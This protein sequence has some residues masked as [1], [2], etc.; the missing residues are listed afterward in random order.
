[1]GLEFEWEALGELDPDR[2]RPAGA[3]L[4]AL[5]RKELIRPHEAIEDTFHFRHMLIRDAAYE[6]I[7]KELRSEFHER[8]AGWL[9]GR[10]EEFD[11][12]VGY[13]LEEAY[14]C[15]AALG[16]L[17]EK[18]RDLGEASAERLTASGRRAY[19]RADPQAA[20]NLLERAAG[21]FEADDPR[22]LGL[23]PLIGRA[24][25]AQGRTD[26]AESVLSEAVEL[27]RAAGERAVAAD[28]GVARADL[29]AHRTAETGAGREAVLR[30]IE[31]AIQVF[32]EVADQAGLA[33]ALLLRGQYRFWGG[34]AAAA[35]PD[36]EEAARLARATGKQAEEAECIQFMCAAMRVGPT[37]VAE[38]LQRLDELGSRAAIN[39][40]LEMAFVLARAHFVAVQGRF[41]EARSLVSQ[42]MA[43]AEEHGLDGVHAVFAAGYV[44]LLAGDIAA[45]EQRLRIV[46]TRYEE[47]GEFG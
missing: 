37:P 47:T 8:F 13:H 43:L 42:A 26:R 41:D 46:C 44:E 33:H 16:R 39:G 28:A 32:E 14:R 40:R 27:G 34:E 45:A 22:R 20:V 2:R 6:R 25:R 11:E 29:R 30:E 35:L 17:D 15:L 36:L 38:A 10:G 9:D 18:A 7:P 4:A 23:L 1:M 19:A 3:Q 21:L 5:V 12:V 24:L 31:A